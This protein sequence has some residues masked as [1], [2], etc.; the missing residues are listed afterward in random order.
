MTPTEQ[1]EQFRAQAR[2]LAERARAF[3]LSADEFIL[4]GEADPAIHRYRQALV[5]DQECVEICRKIASIRGA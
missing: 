4:A 3:R 2:A 5:L 1:R